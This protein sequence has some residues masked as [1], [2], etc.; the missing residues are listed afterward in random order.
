MKTRGVK[1]AAG[2][3]FAFLCAF[4]CTFGAF[5]AK[6]QDSVAIAHDNIG[7]DALKIAGWTTLSVGVASLI[8]AGVVTALQHD[9]NETMNR[10]ILE[11]NKELSSGAFKGKSIKDAD[12]LGQRLNTTNLVLWPVGAL[13]TAGGI[14]M[15]FFGY[16]YDFG[17]DNV[18]GMPAV[19]FAVTPEYQGVSLGWRF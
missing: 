19:N 15:V 6:A 1:R 17:D 7:N 9:L 8:T 4:M 3:G 12:T 16:L 11:D 5:E 14:V 10:A 13:L 18:A 2:L